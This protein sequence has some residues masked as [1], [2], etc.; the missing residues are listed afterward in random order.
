MQSPSITAPL[1]RD[2]VS[3]RAG[4]PWLVA[5]P[6]ASGPTAGIAA[7]VL[8]E[9]AP[10]LGWYLRVGL[11]LD[12]VFGDEAL[13]AVQLGLVPV[14]VIFHVEDLGWERS[15]EARGWPAS[16]PQLLAPTTGQLSLDTPEIWGSDQGSDIL[17]ETGRS[18][19]PRR[20]GCSPSALHGSGF[21]SSSGCL[22]SPQSPSQGRG[23]KTHPQRSRAAASPGAPGAM[24]AWE[25][26][27]RCEQEGCDTRL[28]ATPF[29]SL[30]RR[31]PGRLHSC[32]NRIRN[33]IGLR[34]KHAGEA[35]PG[36]VCGSF[37]APG[38]GRALAVP[39]G[40]C[41]CMAGGA[42]GCWGPGAAPGAAA[43]APWR[44]VGGVVREP[45]PPW[46]GCGAWGGG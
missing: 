23:G 20:A 32:A 14:L 1:L 3:P 33:P 19:Q 30:P 4:L 41:H 21:G 31:G 13:A 28:C 24:A 15:R 10:A 37:G 11:D 42:A 29:S 2:S 8:G 5:D 44:G 40:W 9:G 18:G 16:L 6:W 27:S 34:G 22:A 38:D 36:D 17:H 46:W 35:G 45:L 7:R 43:S 25:D 39:G 26:A 12:V